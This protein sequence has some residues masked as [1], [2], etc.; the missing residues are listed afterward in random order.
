MGFCDSAGKIK[1]LV[2]M[3]MELWSVQNDKKINK[4]ESIRN[5]C[6]NNNNVKSN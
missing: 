4:T 2:I 3:C 6:V 1:L 5:N